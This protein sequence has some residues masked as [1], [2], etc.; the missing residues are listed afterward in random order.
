M[1]VVVSYRC[2]Q[3]I[4]TMDPNLKVELQTV[5]RHNF[6]GGI[7]VFVPNKNDPTASNTWHQGY[8]KFQPIEF[9]PY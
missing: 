1:N 7:G 9:G 6:N 3:A 5:K 4:H 8:A 2:F